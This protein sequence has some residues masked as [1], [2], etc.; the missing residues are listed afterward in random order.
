M[1][2]RSIGD[3]TTISSWQTMN[4]KI[5]GH[6][7]L[8]AH[9]RACKAPNMLRVGVSKVPEALNTPFWHCVILII[10]ISPHSRCAS[11]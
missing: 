6:A 4:G 8:R 10:G 11:P 5:P 9:W 7:P 2:R 1:N 3:S